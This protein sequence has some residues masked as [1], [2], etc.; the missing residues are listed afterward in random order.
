MHRIDLLELLD[1]LTQLTREARLLVDEP[2]SGERLARSR[3]IALLLRYMAEHL[4][5][6]GATGAA[7]SSHESM[8]RE[9]KLIS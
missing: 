4:E 1:T 2:A 5:M 9:E 8:P 3:R 6:L 7:L